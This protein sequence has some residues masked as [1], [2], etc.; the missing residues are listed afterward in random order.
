MQNKQTTKT[1]TRSPSGWNTTPLGTPAIS[2]ANSSYVANFAFQ[3]AQNQNQQQQNQPQQTQN[4][5][6][7]TNIQTHM[8]E[9]IRMASPISQTRRDNLLQEVENLEVK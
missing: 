3:N 5:N 9:Q 1:Q 2:P 7:Q 6:L 4:Q 8:R